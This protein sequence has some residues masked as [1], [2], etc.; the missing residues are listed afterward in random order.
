MLA[1]AD[2]KLT[3]EEFALWLEKDNPAGFPLLIVQRNGALARGR[4]RRYGGEY[5]RGVRR[6]NRSNPDERHGI[7]RNAGV[8]IDRAMQ[9]H[10]KQ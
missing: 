1:A 8:E 4:L 6:R 5:H 3:E 10:G 7:C 2:G 9:Q